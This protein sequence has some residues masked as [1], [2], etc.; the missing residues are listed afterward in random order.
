MELV[1]SV[2]FRLRFSY[3][4]SGAEDR[5]TL[6]KA[7]PPETTHRNYGAG[8]SCAHTIGDQDASRDALREVER[9]RTMAVV[10]NRSHPNNMHAAAQGPV[11][12]KIL[13]HHLELPLIT[14]KAHLRHIG[15]WT[16]CGTFMLV[17]ASAQIKPRT[18]L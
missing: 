11:T 12:K 8:Q 4:S 3:R 18:M 5:N 6:L 15:R 13:D 9:E 16:S 14:P 1:I 2:E 17:V 10:A 7:E